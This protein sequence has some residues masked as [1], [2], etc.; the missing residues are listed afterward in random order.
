[1]SGYKNYDLYIDYLVDEELARKIIKQ[2]LNI[3]YY[4]NNN[5]NVDLDNAIYV[6]DV[7][8]AI[9]YINYNGSN[10]SS[11]I[12]TNDN[13]SAAMFVNMINSKNVFVNASPTLEQSLDLEEKDLLK[14]K[15][16][17]MPNIYKFDGKKVNI[18]IE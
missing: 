8:E 5:I 18:N 3:N 11:G 14:E 15:T 2:G 9:T 7:E 10:Y 12:M 13:N 6:E 4:I 16:I 17:V 1:V